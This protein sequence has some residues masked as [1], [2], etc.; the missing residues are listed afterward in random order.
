L[1]AGA[2]DARVIAD[3]SIRE[4]VDIDFISLG[5]ANNLKTVDLASNNANVF[6]EFDYGANAFISRTSRR[7]IFRP[8]PGFDYGVIVRVHPV[9]FPDRTWICCAGYGEWGT[10]GAAWFLGNKW[11]Q[12]ASRLGND[13]PFVALIQVR[14]EQDES[15]MLVGLFKTSQELDQ[16]L[17]LSSQGVT[18]APAKEASK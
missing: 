2:V 10:S 9:E 5:Y 3:E 6:V 17:H 12:L 15:A 13:D 18:S 11:R 8:A 14:S 1:R 16:F 4:R 7:P